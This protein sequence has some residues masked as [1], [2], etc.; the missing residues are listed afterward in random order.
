MRPIDKYS[1][2]IGMAIG[3]YNVVGNTGRLSKIEVQSGP[4]DFVEKPAEGFYGIG[5]ILVKGDEDLVPANI[6]YGKTILGVEG[7]YAPA[8]PKL[9]VGYTTITE[10]GVTTVYPS[11]GYKGLSS[12]RI[13]TDVPTE[14]VLQEKSVMPGTSKQYIRPDTSDGYNGLSLVTV[15]GDSS[16]VPENI[17]EGVSIFGVKGT[18]IKTEI[19][20]QKLQN[21]SI[22]PG[23][24][25]QTFYPDTANGYTGF[26]KVYINGDSDLISSN[27]REGAT[28]FGVPG[29]YS[30][31]LKLQ[32]KVVT[33]TRDGFTVTPDG[34]F[35]ALASV[36]VN[37]DSNLV[38]G[39]IADG[40][41]IFGVKGSYISPMK[42]ITVLP[43]QDEQVIY[44]AE[45]FY[46]FNKITVAPAAASGDYNEG[47]AAG[48]E[49]RDEEVAQLQ[50][51]ITQL[52]AER[53]AAYQEGYDAGYAAGVSDLGVIRAESVV[54]DDETS[55]CTVTLANGQVHKL[56]YLYD[57][58][59]NVNGMQTSL[60][61]IVRLEGVE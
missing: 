55:T 14:L 7:S 8:D 37:G 23:K 32:D 57:E 9:M 48:V 18:Y 1:L 51:Q 15:A 27:I 22:T 5:E 31:D 50:A 28:I 20:E 39:N 44:P 26:W 40:K 4:S 45:G 41:T 61:D 25:A 36:K 33:P 60:G 46:G 53:D 17:R 11:S 38:A 12:I 19:V 56:T 3:K 54:Y 34:Q 2:A 24:T 6:K 43:S 29:T 47:F 52:Q 21:L 35:N 10:N 30:A 42:A 16:L 58:D 49:S 59:G 13:T